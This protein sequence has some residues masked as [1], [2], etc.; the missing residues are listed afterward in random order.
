MAKLPDSDARSLWGEVKKILQRLKSL[1]NRSPFFGTGMRPDGQGGVVSNDFDG[2]LSVGNAGTKGWAL[3]SAAAAFGSLFLRP[4]SVGN[5]SLA[6][7]VA[8]QYVYDYTSNFALST[9]IAHIRRTT[10]TVPPGFTSAVVNVT[11]RV[12]AVNGTA[13]L[14]YLYA[15]T[16]ISGFNGLALPLPVSASGGSGTNVSPFAVVLSGLTPGGTFSI[17]VDAQ[18]AFG[19]W[20]ANTANT[21]DV[22]GTILWFR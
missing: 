7:P 22:S 4:G 11:G 6:N 15:Q 13:G 3:N 14:D 8:P 12:Y 1:E 10:I 9:T 2:D 5:D 16:N 20:D 18:T 19:A 17:D 21:M